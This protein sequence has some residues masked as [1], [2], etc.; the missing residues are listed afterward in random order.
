M[1][2]PAMY[3]YKAKFV[4]HV[5]DHIVQLAWHIIPKEFSQTVQ[6]TYPDGKVEENDFSDI[7]QNRGKSIL[8]KL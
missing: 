4:P 1:E 6:T 5:H 2:I 3:I 7:V 8:I